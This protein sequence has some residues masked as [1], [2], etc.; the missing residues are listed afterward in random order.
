MAALLPVETWFVISALLAPVGYVL[1]DVVADAM[2]V[3]AVPRV[4]A[5]GKPIGPE[6]ARLMHTTMQTLGRVAIIGGTVLVALINLFMFQGSEQMAQAQKV[7]IYRSVYLLALVIPARLGGRRGDRRLA[8]ATRAGAPAGA[9]AVADAR[10]TRLLA[11]R[12][13]APAPNWWILGGGL[14][15]VLFTLAMGLSK[16]E[17]NQEII[18]AGSMA[19]VLFLMAKLMR[20]LEPEARATLIGT[21]IVIFVFRAVPGPGPGV[22]WWM[23]D[24][25]GFDQPSSRCCR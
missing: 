6:R 7:E 19:I 3:E 20:E 5:D 11:T 22:T 16:L 24:A 18:F 14:L 2:T 15:F 10:S 9:R 25:L 12:S 23:I 21:A 8:G 17:W 4:D 13:E 1:Q